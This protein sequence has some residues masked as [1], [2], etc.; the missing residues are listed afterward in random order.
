[1]EENELTKIVIGA[2]IDVHRQLGPGLLESAYESCLCHELG[3][4]QIPYERQKPLPVNYKGMSLE[5]GYRIDVLVDKK[6]VLEIKSVEGLLP[7][8]EAQM[9]TYMRLGGWKAGLLINFNVPLLKQGIR[10]LVLGLKE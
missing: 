7:I 6:V 1:M 9:L 10:R 5:C 3:L 2:A 4:R 8:H